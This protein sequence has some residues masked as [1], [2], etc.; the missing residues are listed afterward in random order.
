MAKSIVTVSHHY[1]ITTYPSL[2]QSEKGDK[3]EIRHGVSASQTQDSPKQHPPL[4]LRSRFSSSILAYA[5]NVTVRVTVLVLS[6]VG[7]AGASAGAVGGAAGA[8]A[9]KVSSGEAG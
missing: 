3:L 5:M 8:R 6:A 9:G 1:Y 2:I 7:V 4:P